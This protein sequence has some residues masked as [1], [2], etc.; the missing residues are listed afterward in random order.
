MRNETAHEANLVRSQGTAFKLNR[1]FAVTRPGELP[2]EDAA[3]ALGVLVAIGQLD[4]ASARLIRKGKTGFARISDRI[5]IQGAKRFAIAHEL[6]HWEQHQ[7]KSQLFLCTEADLRDYSKSVLEIEAN[8]FAAELLMPAVLFRPKC[9]HA[10]PSLALVD[11]LAEEFV[12]SRTATAI[13]LVQET[14]RKCMVVYSENGKVR[15]WKRKEG[16]TRLWLEREQKIHPHSMAYECLKGTDVPNQMMA[17]PTE[18]W[19]GHLPFDLNAEVREQSLKLGR[20]PGILT[21][22]WILQ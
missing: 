15:W 18:A 10:D 2:L 14:M 7:D 12:T 5:V 8:H 6:G 3:M 13:R 4:G 9:E 17:V 11:A 21:L 19:F 1:R 20:Y 22:L 16:A